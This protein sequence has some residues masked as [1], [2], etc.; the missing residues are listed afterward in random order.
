MSHGC[1]QLDQLDTSRARSILYRLV[2][3]GGTCIQQQLEAAGLM[4]PVV[5]A[6]QP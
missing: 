5:L 3:H 1:Q 6:L 2:N 4:L